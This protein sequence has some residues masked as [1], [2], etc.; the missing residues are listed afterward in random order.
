MA[1]NRAV[2]RDGSSVQRTVTDDYN[3]VDGGV[4]KEVI[5]NTLPIKSVR[6]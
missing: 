2:D 5:L 4:V 1:R 6:I 3:I